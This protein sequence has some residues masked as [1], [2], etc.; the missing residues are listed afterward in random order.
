[1]FSTV[2]Y[3]FKFNGFDFC[4][5]LFSVLPE[6]LL[7][8]IAS[9]SSNIRQ[10]RQLFGQKSRKNH[11]F[12]A[13]FCGKV[14]M[15]PY[16]PKVLLRFYQGLLTPLGRSANFVCLLLLYR[17]GNQFAW[18]NSIF[19]LLKTRDFPFSSAFEAFWANVCFLWS[20]AICSSFP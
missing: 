12:L 9:W 4:L 8:E 13:S 6:F 2:L 16:Y 1:M 15:T 17:Q 18:Q 7:S 3:L 11:H 20:L 19:H 10:I 14:K 5:L